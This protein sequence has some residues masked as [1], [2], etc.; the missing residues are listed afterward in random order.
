LVV[1]HRPP[2]DVSRYT[3]SALVGSATIVRTRPVS[4]FVS[5]TPFSI[6]FDRTGPMFVQVPA[7]PATAAL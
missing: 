7:A 5:L 6:Q 1:F 4:D 3:T 2:P